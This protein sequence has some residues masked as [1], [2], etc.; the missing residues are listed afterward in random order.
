MTL[1]QWGGLVTLASIAVSIVTLI[2]VHF[3]P[4]GR[5]PI[6]DP[7]SQYRLTR[8][9]A[10]TITSSFFSAIAGIGAIVL[11]T[12]LSGSAA[13]ATDVLLGI[14]VISRIL[15]PVIPMDAPGSTPTRRGRTHYLLAIVG[16]AA[17]TAAIFVAGGLLQ[18]AGHEDTATWSTVL[19]IVAA[20]GAVGLLVGVIARR[21][22]LFGL[23]ERIIYLGFMP[24]LALV[25]YIAVRG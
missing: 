25:G 15:L 17:I 22:G 11:F 19:G 4:T 13:I 5:N 9:R 7:V 18:A 1:L 23:F 24:W 10:W 16:F 3:L 6:R 8:F 21:S 14:Y 2:V 20:V 12:A